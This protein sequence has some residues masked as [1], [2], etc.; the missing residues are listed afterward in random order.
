MYNSNQ[1]VMQTYGKFFNRPKREKWI[2]D[3]WS[4]DRKK[5]IWSNAQ[6]NIPSL[7]FF[8]LSVDEEEFYNFYW[9]Q[10]QSDGFQIAWFWPRETKWLSV[11]LLLIRSSWIWFSLVQILRAITNLTG[12]IITVNFLH[13]FKTCKP[14]SLNLYP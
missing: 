10:Y 3:K 13:Y 4:I 7:V 12:I 11:F 8:L 9:R 2:V 5:T 1:K 14:G 6:E